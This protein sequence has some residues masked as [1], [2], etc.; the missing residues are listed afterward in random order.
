MEMKK[1]EDKAE[2]FLRMAEDYGVEN[3]YLFLTHFEMYQN[4]IEMLHKLAEAI[5]TEGMLVEKEYVKSRKNLYTNPAVTEYNRTADSAH[6]TASTLMK[7]IKTLGAEGGDDND[8]LL[9]VLG[10]E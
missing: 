5:D 6:K 4:Q 9:D 8:P 7:I 3:N 10:G 1:F 2:E